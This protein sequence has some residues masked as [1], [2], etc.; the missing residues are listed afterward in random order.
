MLWMSKFIHKKHNVSILLYHIVCPTKYR[1]AVFASEVDAKIKEICAEIEKRFEIEFLE[2]G[3]DDNHVHFLVQSVPSY[4]PK[5]L[6][7]MIKSI[8]A[9]EVFTR[10]SKSQTILM[11]RAVLVRRLFRQHRRRTSNWKDDKELRSATR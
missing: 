2:I 6:V 10:L 9:R 1:R 8:T 7:Q 11:G 5:Q 4:S 3:S